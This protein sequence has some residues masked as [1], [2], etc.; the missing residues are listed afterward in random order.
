VTED[1]DILA[2]KRALRARMLARRA[3]LAAPVRTA[4]AAAVAAHG[5]TFLGPPRPGAIV[6]AFAPLPEELRIWPLLRRLAGEGYVLGLPVMQGRGKVLLFR[7]WKAGDALEARSMGI[8]EPK[9]DKP[10]VVPDI[11]IVPLLAFDALGWRL[12]YGGGY[13]DRTLRALRACKPIVAVGIGYD[14][15]AVDAVP[16]LDYDERLDWVLTATGPRWCVGA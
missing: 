4:A 16:H 3:G 2:Q 11:V 9:P 14:E 8:A 1:G 6:S 7:A 15:Q 10:V 5:L 13:Y 12:G